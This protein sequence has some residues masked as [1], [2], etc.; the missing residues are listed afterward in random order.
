MNR[1]LEFFR[2]YSRWVAL[3]LAVLLQA[4]MLVKSFHSHAAQPISHQPLVVG[5]ASSTT[6]SNSSLGAEDNHCFVCDFAFEPC[7]VV[8]CLHVV[9]YEQMNSILRVETI[10][11][12][13]IQSFL[14]P[15]LRAPPSFS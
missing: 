2:R 6:E 12:V 11:A 13:Q 4:S 3:L 1:P 14:H 5:D 10:P 7:E 8:A 9:C 15:S